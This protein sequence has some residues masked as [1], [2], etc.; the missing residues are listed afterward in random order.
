MTAT[1][2]PREVVTGRFIQLEPYRAEHLP[3]L[4]TA[5]GRPE[6]FAG[7]YGGGAAG[8]PADE[9]AF[10][11]WAPKYFPHAAGNSYVVVVRGGPHDREVVGA[12]SLADF[13]E[14]KEH[15]HIGW[16]AFD[17]RVWATQVNPE[18]KLLMLGLA[19]EHGYGRVKIQADDINTRSKAAIAKLGARFEGVERRAVRRADGSWRD[20][21]IFSVLVEEWPTVKAGLEARLSHWGER[22]VLFRSV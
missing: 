11:E 21:A 15:A 19:F 14:Q 6:V 1:R 12:S 20:T 3:G 13:D 9:A 5:I 8:L 10:H 7:G 16:T 4:W 18:A 17:P 2:P 22:P